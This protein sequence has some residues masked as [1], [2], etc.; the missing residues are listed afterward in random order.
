ME[1]RGREV[2]KL[3]EDYQ[4]RYPGP[5]IVAMPQSVCPDLIKCLLNLQNVSGFIIPS[6]SATGLT[7]QG[8]TVGCFLQSGRRWQLPERKVGTIIVLGHRGCIGFYMISQALAQGI[9]WIAYLSFGTLQRESTPIFL[10]SRLLEELARIFRR[11]YQR[12]PLYCLFTKLRNKIPSFLMPYLPSGKMEGRIKKVLESNSFPLLTPE[13]FTEQRILLV[14][15]SLAWGGA[16]RQIV[17]TLI[18]LHERGYKDISLL[19]EY[20]GDRPDHDFYL[21]QLQTRGIAVQQ[22]RQGVD[23]LKNDQESDVHWSLAVEAVLSELPAQLAAEIGDYLLEMSRIRPQVVHIWQ[24]STSVK[25]GLAAVLLGIPHI[26]I[27]SRNM[28]PFRFGYYLPYMRAAYRVLAGLRQVTLLNNSHA[29][30]R[31]YA[32]WLG[33]PHTRYRVLFNGIRQ[34]HFERV[35]ADEVKTYRQKLGI[36]DAAKVVGSIFRFY[37]EKDPLLWVET[38]ASVAQKKPDC[39]FLLIGT[40]PMHE[41][42]VKKAQS[43][44]V[45]DRL[46]LPGTDKNPVLPLS[47][48]DVFLLT[49]RLEGTPNVVIEAQMCGVPVVATAAGGTID[50]VDNGNTGWILKRYTPSDLAE[51]VLYILENPEWAGKACQLS[52]QFASHRF[53]YCRMINETLEAYKMG[54]PSTEHQSD[55]NAEPAIQ[56]ITT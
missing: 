40:G 31:D 52:R 14:N 20:L 24:D 34:D 15:S 12:L 28:A 37:S 19:C 17:N 49:S 3:L 32:R 22:L 11:A 5:M 27:G 47:V 9:F 56:E 53:G 21:E 4:K 54:A 42:I 10:L 33:L 25:A 23:A 55:L 2:I 50:T 35:T 1:G 41:Q 44:G 13:K 30:A 45:S 29:G 18:G 6:E 16:E 8:T 48:M 43:L 51:R 36:P 39:V 26:L 7:I 46:F 38:I